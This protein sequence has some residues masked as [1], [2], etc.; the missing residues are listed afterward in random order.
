MK[1]P[2]VEIRDL[3]I[4]EGLNS[5]GF[6]ISAGREPD[7]PDRTITVYQTGGEDPIP[8]LDIWRPSIQVRVRA[9]REDIAW[10]RLDA[11]RNFLSRDNTNLFVNGTRYIGVWQTTDILPLGHDENNR[12]RLVA[13]FRTEREPLE[14]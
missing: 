9:E 13:N 10:N 12:Q 4:S 5:D 6:L 3:L 14:E 8:D 11:I 2:N 1:A 7:S